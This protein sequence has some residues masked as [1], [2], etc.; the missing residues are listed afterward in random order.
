MEKARDRITEAHKLAQAMYNTL[1]VATMAQQDAKRPR[2]GKD[3]EVVDA[4]SKM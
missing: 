1:R 4:D 3:G 2:Q